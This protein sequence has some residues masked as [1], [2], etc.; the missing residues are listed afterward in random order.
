M[1]GEQEVK[2]Y[3]VGAATLAAVLLAT[4]A[5]AAETVTLAPID[6]V[7]LTGGG[8]VVLRYGATQS[9]TLLQG[10]TQYTRFKVHGKS[11]EI[12]A[13]NSSCPHNY[14]LEIEIVL[15]RVDAV[16]IQGGGAIVAMAGFPAQHGIDA[17]V[18][19]G[20]D[21]D[22]RAVQA[23]DVDAAVNGGGEI[24]VAAN[25]TLNAAVSG[26]G[27]IAYWGKPNVS[28]AVSGGGSI[29]HVD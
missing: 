2:R 14:D 15:P 26:G 13:C 23:S 24:K 12:E 8:H 4:P 10:S 5:I 21:I 7:G 6:S 17:A 25:R 3:L 20:G 11:L 1:R 28:E 29:D 27:R 19:G 18:S 22:L 16:A 9:V